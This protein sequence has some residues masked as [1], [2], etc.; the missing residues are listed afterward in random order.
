VR[1]VQ[2]ALVAFLQ[3][4]VVVALVAG[5]RAVAH[6]DLTPPPAVD[7]AAVVH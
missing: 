7:R 6:T 5:V 2:Y 3:A 1:A 4:L